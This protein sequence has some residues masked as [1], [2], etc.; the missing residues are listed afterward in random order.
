MW[1]HKLAIR[2][3]MAVALP[4]PLLSLPTAGYAQL[5]EQTRLLPSAPTHRPAGI[6]HAS[7]EPASASTASS[8][9]ALPSP[10]GTASGTA[11]N[12][13]S[14]VAL[15]SPPP[16][17]SV[18]AS[19]NETVVRIPLGP[20]GADGSLEAT[21]YKP[22]GPGPFPVVIFNH[23]KER[24][25]PRQQLR[26]RPIS[27]A[28][29]FVR[30]GYVVIAPNRRGFANSDGV[31]TE[32]L[33]DIDKIGLQQASDIAL[34]VHYLAQL[35]Y[36][37]KS[38]I[39]MV[40]ASQGGLAAMAYGTQADPGVLGIVNFSGGLRQDACERWQQAMIDAF[41]D[42]G[43]HVRLPT[44]WLYGDNDQFWPQALAQQMLAVYRAGG[45]DAKLIDFGNYKDNAHRLVSDRDG[46][47]IWWPVMEA[48]LDRIGLPTAVRFQISD[49]PLPPPSGYAALNDIAALPYLDEAGRA[50]YRG[51]L[52]QYPS[53]A[54]ALSSTGAWSWA[55]GGDDPVSLALENCQHNSRLPCRLYAIDNAVV[56][57]KP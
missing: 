40:G 20:T 38:R 25:E 7:I 15:L 39:L 31:Y 46:V 45:G 14:T 57:T 41:Q 54:F 16:L 36:A 47:G 37:D 6:I 22:D 28:R 26:S 55:E 3:V 9:L 12:A 49:A 23:G 48:F 27:L 30:R 24:G 2:L 33:C 56:W 44:L 34:T 11:V 19:M 50:G 4:L 52:R 8:V 17:L 18:A 21:I 51:F 1:R 13:D 10:T 35:P 5:G 53:R 43:Q 42:Y 29:E 32:A